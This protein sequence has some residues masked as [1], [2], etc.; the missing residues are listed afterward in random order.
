M[1]VK[2]RKKKIAGGRVSLYLDIYH[3][4]NRKY[5]FLQ[6]YLAK[7]KNANRETLAIAESIAAKRQL[8][9]S[10]DSY[11]YIP[12]FKRSA[13]FLEYFMKIPRAK[14][15]N[16]PER[17]TLKHLR[18]FTGGKVKISQIDEK[19]CEN[20]KRYLSDSLAPNSVKT[21]LA[22]LNIALN[23]AAKD[24]IINK[25][26]LQHVK[27]VKIDDSERVFLTFD[28]LQKLTK[29]KFK[30]SDIKRAFLFTCYT[31]LR[32]SDVKKLTWKQITSNGN[33]YNLEFRQQKTG[34]F[35]YFPLSEM[36][37]EILTKGQD[38]LIRLPHSKVFDIPEHGQYNVVLKLLA[39]KAGINKNVTSH[40]GRHT[41]ATLMLTHGVDI[42]TVSKLL[43][44]KSLSTTQIYAKIIDQ[45]KDEAV[46]ML[47]KVQYM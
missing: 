24:K 1:S 14:G 28:E 13:D 45:K 41:F 26:P 47:P 8:E 11:G 12:K 31:G 39:K 10:F 20:F 35:E 21:Y 44:H 40:T 30:K 2:L 7:D 27:K 15:M 16:R 42:Y 46:D 37:S 6:L 29:T 18:I 9:I 32:Y 19:W 23:Q 25:N 36:A 4:G 33:R 5:E 38:N 22:C 17:S 43:G 3:K 34:S